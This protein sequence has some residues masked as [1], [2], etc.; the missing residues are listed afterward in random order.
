[1]RLER[2]LVRFG[3]AEDATEIWSALGIDAVDDLPALDE[4]SFLARVG[5]K[6]ESADGAR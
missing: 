2:R 6:R 3:M 1:V 5:D 4:S